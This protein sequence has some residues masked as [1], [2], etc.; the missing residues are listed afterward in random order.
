MRNTEEIEGYVK[1][2]LQSLQVD[3]QWIEVDPEYA[4]TAICCEK[5]GFEI[6]NTGNTI[7]VASKR[8]EKKYSA[9]I[10]RG[11]EKLDVNR[12]VRELMG[13][14]RLSF[15]SS[16]K[17]VELTGMMI[18]GVTPF[19]LPEFIEI[20]LDEKLFE[21]DFVILGSGDRSSKLKISPEE[22]TK[23]PNSTI[24]EGLSIPSGGE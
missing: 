4:D 17:T 8:G 24:V 11:T 3:Y 20:Y 13:V 6:S 22:L 5:Y 18:G 14:S 16:E 21:L 2:T 1:S 23:L 7:I 15:A 10:V 12:K 9:C 19:A